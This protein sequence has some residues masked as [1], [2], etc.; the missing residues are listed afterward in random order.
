MGN[1]KKFFV[2]VDKTF[3]GGRGG[4]GVGEGNDI[5]RKY[6]FSLIT[7]GVRTQLRNLFSVS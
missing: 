2:F 6:C 5:F 7:I 1:C 3:L 4:S